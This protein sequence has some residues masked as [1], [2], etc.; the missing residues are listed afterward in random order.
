M[1][2]N[3]PMNRLLEGDVG[4]GKTVVSAIA[5]LN[6]I[7]A[8]YQVAFMAPTEI[9]ATQHFKNLSELLKDTNANI[10][11]FTRGQRRL[12]HINKNININSCLES[13]M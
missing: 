12:S 2:R 1:E 4:S 7:D 8:G 11:L 5:T 6:A 13:L 3:F 10:A 9:L